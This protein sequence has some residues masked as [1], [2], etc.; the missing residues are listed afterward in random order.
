MECFTRKGRVKMSGLSWIFVLVGSVGLLWIGYWQFKKFSE[1]EKRI[2]KSDG[3]LFDDAGIKTSEAIQAPVGSVVLPYSLAVDVPI[4]I[5]QSSSYSS[6][7][8]I[9]VGTSSQPQNTQQ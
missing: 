2:A 9:E 7:Q 4:S 6:G 3:S 5:V 8:E 1:L